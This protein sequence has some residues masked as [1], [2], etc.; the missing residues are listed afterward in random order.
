MGAPGRG[1]GGAWASRGGAG[2]AGGGAWAVWGGAWMAGAGR[3]GSLHLHPNLGVRT[4]QIRAHPLLSRPRSSPG[5]YT[6][7]GDPTGWALSTPTLGS[8]RV[9]ASGP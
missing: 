4:L 2:M 6:T 9:L 5:R 3:G 8:R 7:G 1:R